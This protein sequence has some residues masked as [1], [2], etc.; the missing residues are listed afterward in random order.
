MVFQFVEAIFLV[1]GIKCMSSV[2]T[3]TQRGDLIR[4]TARCSSL[5]VG[6]QKI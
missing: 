2:K 4:E 1:R 3:T 5:S 6:E